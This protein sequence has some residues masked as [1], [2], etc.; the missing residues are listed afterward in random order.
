MGVRFGPERWG[1]PN[2]YR[3]TEDWKKALTSIVELAQDK[4]A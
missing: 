2:F 1:N 3:K 4:L